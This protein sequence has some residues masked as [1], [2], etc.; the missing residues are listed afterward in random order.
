[1][2]RKNFLDAVEKL[3]GWRPY[4]DTE[5]MGIS[6]GIATIKKGKQP[7]RTVKW[8]YGTIFFSLGRFRLYQKGDGKSVELYYMEVEFALEEM[9]SHFL[10]E[11]P[12]GTED[13]IEFISP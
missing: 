1:M 13:V 12:E 2:T 4:P 8:F 9:Y 3:G 5:Q 10:R 11:Y 7:F 6:F